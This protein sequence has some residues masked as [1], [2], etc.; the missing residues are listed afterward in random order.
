ML[1]WGW[2]SHVTR[3]WL[4]LCETMPDNPDCIFQ[5]W[6][7]YFQ[8]LFCDACFTVNYLSK[9]MLIGRVVVIKCTLIKK[10]SKCS[11]RVA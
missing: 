9:I 3:G 4:S 8:R 1:S 7:L 2:L 10:K 5:C 6:S 11:L